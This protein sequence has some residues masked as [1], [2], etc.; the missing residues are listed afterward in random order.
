MKLLSRVHLF[1]T[2]WTA[3]HPGALNSSKCFSVLV[4]ISPCGKFKQFTT[5]KAVLTIVIGLET[6]LC[7]HLVE[8]TLE[9]EESNVPGY[10]P[11]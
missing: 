6:I 9:R 4:K 10:S 11:F 2:P 8:S 1:A 5:D 3:A 7:W